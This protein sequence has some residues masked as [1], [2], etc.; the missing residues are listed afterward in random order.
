VDLPLV[1]QGVVLS[2]A[3]EAG[4]SVAFSLS[5]HASRKAV[6]ASGQLGE[7]IGS[8][9]GCRLDGSRAGNGGGAL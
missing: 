7:Q 3:I 2:G 8:R 4:A 6:K 9:A 5:S 1:S